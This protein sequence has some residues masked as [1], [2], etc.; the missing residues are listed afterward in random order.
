MFAIQNIKTGK[1]VTGTDYSYQPPHQITEFNQALTYNTLA[2]AKS[3]FI[4]R[5][6][7]R[8]YRVVCIKPIEVRSVIDFDCDH[9]YRIY[10]ED[11]SNIGE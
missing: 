5:R 10:H 3:D 2:R 9:K 11:W 7:G 4:D 6:C 8:N 1:F